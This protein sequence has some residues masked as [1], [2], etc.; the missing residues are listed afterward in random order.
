MRTCG[1]AVCRLAG[2]GV[3][4]TFLLGSSGAHPQ[5]GQLP[6]LHTNESYI[7][8]VTR[9][10]VLAVDDPM[11]VFAFVLDSLPDRVKVY[12]TEN[13]YY[14]TFHHRGVEY[15]GNIRID[16]DDSGGQTV[17][18]VYFPQETDWNDN[19]PRTH[20]VLDASR[21]VTVEKL[22]RFDYRL[23][24][25]QKSVLFALND[26]SGV[27]PPARAIAADETFIG[28][29]FDEGGLRFFLLYNRPRHD[30]YYVLDEE[31]GVAD[32]FL[33]APRTDRILIGQRTG[34][35]L[36][37]DFRTD[38]KILIGV[39]ERNFRLNSYFDGPFDQLPDAFIKGDTLR[40]AILQVEP[41]LKGQIDRFGALP[42][43]A[44]RYSIDFYMRYRA[45]ADLYAFHACASARQH[46]ADY[47]DCFVSAKLARAFVARRHKTRGATSSR[48]HAGTRG[49]RRTAS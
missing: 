7:D 30:F 8:E 44:V 26:L 22:D 15:A 49:R 20:I 9:P 40:D 3:I 29:I 14:F 42:G 31:R 19:P 47:Y 25:K 6:T 10:T 13:Y 38:R 17:H 45:V 12:P 1:R 2:L 43:G 16:P 48:L 32:E 21:G 46:A 39:Y 23:S 35:A 37:R 41:G 4:G 18:F 27:T 28:P 34:Y 5:A 36:Y 11:A 24:Y 33:P